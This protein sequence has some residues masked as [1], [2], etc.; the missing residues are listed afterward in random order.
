MDS[1]KPGYLKGAVY[2]FLVGDALGVPV[3]F[4]KRG[5][6]Y[7]QDMIGYGSHYQPVGTWSD[8]SSLM[9]ATCASIKGRYRIHYEDIMNRFYRWFQFGEYSPDGKVFDIGATTVEA[10]SRYKKGWEP[11][12]CGLDHI[13]ANGNG[14][15]MR[16]LPL[17]FTD[18]STEDIYNISR[19]THAHEISLKSC[20]IYIKVARGLLKK[21]S[22]MDIIVA[23]NEAEPFE[24]LK[25]IN[26]L[27]EHEIAS[28]GYVVH[29]LEAALWCLATTKSFRECVLK[30]VNLG[31]DTDT[32]AAVA[33]G[34]AGIVY[35]YE[36]IPVG[37]IKKL[38][39]KE[40]IEECLF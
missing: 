6:F 24:R 19:L 32:T 10:I 17:A 28:T 7:I 37:W 4:K 22:I 2:G 29:T 20:E 40:L 11:L 13:N 18:A 16:I 34:L 9:L 23:L 8:D 12:Q 26:I 33:G 39:A 31:D 5:S 30:A 36:G 35:G 14:S 1:A 27:E 25:H 38:R 21:D 15:L 3:E